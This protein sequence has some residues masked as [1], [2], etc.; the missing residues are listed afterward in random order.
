MMRSPR[1]CARRFTL[2]VLSY[3]S[4]FLVVTD[5]I[6]ETLRL[7]LLPAHMIATTSGEISKF[8]TVLALARMLSQTSTR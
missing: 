8:L 7:S 6:T 4:M 3:F 5:Q 2:R 1:Y